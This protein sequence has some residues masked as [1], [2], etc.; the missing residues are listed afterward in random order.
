MEIRPLREGDAT[1]V[2]RLLGELGYP[3]PPDPERMTAWDEDPERHALVAESDGHLAGAIALQ[4]CRH[5]A[6]PGRFGRIVAMVVDERHR[7]EG[8]GRALVEAA[9]AIARDAGCDEIE[10]TSGRRRDA[11]HPFYRSLGFEDL[12]D[13]S[14]RYKRE[15]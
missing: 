2:A 9:V 10:V 3:Q 6:R 8:L 15:L 4:L 1:E 5:F 11:S 7:Q 12:T 14:V 13:R